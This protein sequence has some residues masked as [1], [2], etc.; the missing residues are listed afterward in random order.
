M[1]RAICAELLRRYPVGLDAS[2]HADQTATP[3]PNTVLRAD[4]RRHGNVFWRS[5]SDVYGDVTHV[6]RQYRHHY[7][8]YV[9][10]LLY[11]RTPNM[12]LPGDQFY[13]SKDKARWLVHFEFWYPC[14]LKY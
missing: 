3:Q 14:G 12:R 5:C 4:Y 2:A 1:F 7:I 6:R 8:M 13:L 9:M 10:A 11:K